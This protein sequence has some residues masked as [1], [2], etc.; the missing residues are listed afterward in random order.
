V[1]LITHTTMGVA[2]ILRRRMERKI[3]D[4]FGEGQI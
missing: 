2:R 1:S 4:V 3:E